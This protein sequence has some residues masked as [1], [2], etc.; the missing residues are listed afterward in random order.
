[1]EKTNLTLQKN[2][3]LAVK[4]HLENNL[5]EAIDL[6]EQVLKISPKHFA[7][8]YN[9]AKA[10]YA[11]CENKK[12]INFIFAEKKLFMTIFNKK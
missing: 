10:F 8:N 2:F 12:A 3:S 11:L 1:M 9:I 5:K 7:A 4:K 6:Y